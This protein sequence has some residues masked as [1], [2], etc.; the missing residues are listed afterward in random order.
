MRIDVSKEIL[1]LDG[2]PLKDDRKKPLTIGEAMT[3]GLMAAFGDEK[4][5]GKEK[6]ERFMLASRIHKQKEVELTAEEGAL[7]QKLVNQCYPSPLVV[8]QV[9][10]EIDRK[11]TFPVKLKEV[12]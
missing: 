2:E 7:I 5:S 12:K 3:N 4:L 9:I 1:D 6:L 8:A 10:L 11:E